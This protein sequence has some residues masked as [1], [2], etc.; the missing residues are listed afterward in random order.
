MTE[1]QKNNNSIV[2][3]RLSLW[4][5]ALQMQTS[6][7]SS[8]KPEQTECS[9]HFMSLSI[10]ECDWRITMESL[11]KLARLVCAGGQV[12]RWILSTGVDKRLQAVAVGKWITTLGT[13][14]PCKTIR[15]SE[16]SKCLQL[17]SGIHNGLESGIHFGMQS[18]R[19]PEGWNP[20]SKG[21]ESRIQRLGSGIHWGP[22]W[23]LLRGA[24]LR[25]SSQW[26]RPEVSRP[27]W[28]AAWRNGSSSEPY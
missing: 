22:S 28:Q 3:W 7:L 26:I 4:L 19:N 5:I 2:N 27:D 13:S 21:L 25:Q 20:E 18:D 6:Q 16:S 8:T 14:C 10:S 24:T 15:N 12:K 23:I 11:E 1:E 17:E 9:V